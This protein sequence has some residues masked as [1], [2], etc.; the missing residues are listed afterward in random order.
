MLTAKQILALDDLP[1]RE[2]EI[3]EWGGSVYVRALT[4]AERDQ[5][6]RSLSQSSTISRAAIVVMCC[7]DGDGNPLFSQSDVAALTNK[8]GQALERIVSAALAFNALTDEA[9]ADVGKG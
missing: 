9:L 4:G 1:R 7:V 8:N 3:P 6:E 2:V 5:L